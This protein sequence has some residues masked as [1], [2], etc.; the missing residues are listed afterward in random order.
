M[1]TEEIFK[2]QI[3]RVYPKA[4]WKEEDELIGI[5]IEDC[6]RLYVNK[7]LDIHIKFEGLLHTDERIVQA[8]FASR[9]TS[10][11]MSIYFSKSKFQA[12]R[13]TFGVRQLGRLEMAM[14]YFLVFK[15][16]YDSLIEFNSYK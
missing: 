7:K 5:D 1:T 6:G 10:E 16:M 13:K 2:N 14:E 3:Y 4:N 9:I 15:N 12:Y 11:Y 8:F